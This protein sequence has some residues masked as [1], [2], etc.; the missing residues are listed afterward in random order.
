MSHTTTVKIEFTDRTALRAICERLGLKFQEGLHNV[1]LY[2]GTVIADFSV[3]LPGWKY[4]IAINGN[5]I[6][7]DNYNGNW[8]KL[9]ELEK[10]QDQYSREVTVMQAELN[11]MTW[12]EEIEEDG[13]IVLNIFDYSS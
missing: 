13:T 11:G 4:P 1:R 7:W 2:Q 8:G 9:Q 6:K 5:T 12:T 3:T 10:L